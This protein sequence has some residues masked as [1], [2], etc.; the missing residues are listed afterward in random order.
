MSMGESMDIAMRPLIVET[1]EDPEYSCLLLHGGGGDPLEFKSLIPAISPPDVGIRYV[2]PYAPEIRLTLFSGHLMRAWF[3]VTDDNLELH[4]DIVGIEASTNTVLSLIDMEH[5]SGIAYEKIIIGGFSQ[6]GAIA[7]LA[8]LRLRASLAAAFCL[9]GYLPLGEN[10]QTIASIESRKTPIFIGH[11][12]HDELVP[13]HLAASACLTL[14]NLGF[15]V[16]G[17]E[18]PIG[19]QVSMGELRLL[20]DWLSQVIQL[21]GPCS[22]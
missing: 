17:E 12:A 20:R 19:H 3:D 10:V 6:G 14:R 18:Y 5:A 15:D 13:V 7:L 16:V 22:I 1:A 11:G 2:L 8:A 9:S 21:K 4:Q